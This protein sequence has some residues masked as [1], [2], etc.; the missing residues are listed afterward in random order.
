M[1]H[2]YLFIFIFLIFSNLNA[3]SYSGSISG[4]VTENAT[5]MP[6]QGVDILLKNTAKGTTTDANGNFKITSIPTGNYIVE[7]S[8]LGYES[9]AQRIQ[10]QSNKNIELSF[11]LKEGKINLSEVAVE[12]KSKSRKLRE[13]AMPISVISMKEINGAVSDVNDV[14]S[15]TVGVKMRVSGGV[16]SSSRISLRGLEGKRIGIFVDEIPLNDNSDFVDLNDIPVDMIDRIEIYKGIVPAKLGGSSVGGAVNVVLKEYPP[17]YVD[18]SYQIAS[19]NTQKTSTVLKTNKNGYEIGIGGAY[20]SSDNNY[21]MELPLEKGKFVRRNH[22]KFEKKT[23][24][25]GLKVKNKWW[26]DKVEFESVYVKTKKELQGIEYH[27]Q[28]AE[29]FSEGFFINNKLEKEDFLTTGLDFDISIGYLYSVFK[30]QNKAMHRYN[31]DGSIM[32]PPITRYG[33]EILGSQPNDANTPTHSLISRLNLNYLLNDWSSLNLNLTYR[34][35][36]SSPTD[37]LKEKAIGHKTNFDSRMNSNVAG[38]NY[39]IR[40]FENKLLNSLT[41]KYYYYNI[42]TKLADIFDVKKVEDIHNVKN[43]WGISNAIRYRFTPDFLLKTSFSYDVR[44]PSETELIGDG[45]LIAPS[46]TLTPER[47]KSVNIGLLYDKK[48]GKNRRFSVEMN[49]FYM[50]LKDMIR[51]VGGPLQSNYVNFGEMQT[52]GA[53][54]EIKWDA[55]SFLY[56]YT[57]ATYQDLRDAREYQENSSVPNPTKGDR[58]PNIPYFFVNAG[59]ELHRENLF[60]GHEQNSRMFVNSSF[61]EEY[62]YDFEQS[63]YQQRRIPRAFTTDIGLEHSFKNQRFTIGFQANNI[64]DAKVISEF[65]RPLPGRNY[66]LKIRYLLK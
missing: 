57:N 12:G 13:Q 23:I 19:F 16:G 41:A 29:R 11:S 52:L 28:E 21:E 43:D 15:R 36:S 30:F 32:A 65:N 50:H 51:F 8:F 9:Q 5:N 61:V 64:T 17:F 7:V 35:V 48:I 34:N 39:E 24:G 3:Q 1:K 4:K 20:T 66:A 38:L 53:E 26:F 63:I 46:G 44:L 47:N 10:I 2:T 6:L 40:L 25:G 58:I 62:F 56:L 49:G 14:L 37:P 59:L 18:L 31:W 42:K 60:G 45:F 22:D 33:G 55:T 27:I 54:L